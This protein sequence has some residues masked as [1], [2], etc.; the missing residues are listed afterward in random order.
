MTY[1]EIILSVPVFK[2]EQ[3]AH[4]GAGDYKYGNRAFND[5]LKKGYGL[6][7][8]LLHSARLCI[9]RCGG[10]LSGISEKEITAPLPPLFQ[11]ICTDKGVI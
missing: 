8:Q 6:S 9:P 1:R 3:Y 11:K 7:S 2:P 10:V 4:I 5:G